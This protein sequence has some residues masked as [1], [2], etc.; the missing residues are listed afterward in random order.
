[1]PRPLKSKAFSF[2]DSGF[3][4]NRPRE[5]FSA[6]DTATGVFAVADGVGLWEG[7][8]YV[9][10]YPKVS[11]SARLSRAF[12]ESFVNYLSHHPRA[13]VAAGFRAGNRAAA[14]VNKN[15]SKYDAFRKHKGL[16]AAT[17]AMGRVRGRILEWAHICDA[18]VAVINK[19]G[20]LKF[21]EDG[22]RHRFPWPKD[23]RKYDSSTWTFF[24]RTLVRNAVGKDGGL[25]GYGVITGEQEAER[26]L[27]VGRYRLIPGDVVVFYTDGFAPYFSLPMFRKAL[28]KIGSKENLRK[29]MKGVIG[30]KTAALRKTLRG[31]R[32]D[33]GASVDV[34]EGKLRRILGKHFRTIEYA[35]EKSLIMARVY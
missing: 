17:A 14:R 12:C 26:Y 22:C 7:I 35:K 10:R 30:N 32:L 28:A 21:R 11:G 13:T 18:G 9:G 8:E 25:L 33:S 23:V 3:L 24:A 27:E 34:I 20:K 15:R 5:D 19:N 1:M 4:K 6:A 29:E 31:C 2:Y 16:Y